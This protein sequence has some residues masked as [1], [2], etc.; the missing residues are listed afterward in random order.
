MQ[1]TNYT[2]FEDFGVL[3]NSENSENSE[4]MRNIDIKTVDPSTLVDI[5][6]VTVNT[7]LPKNDRIKDFI[8]QI[9]NPYCYKCGKTIVKA[10]YPETDATFEEIFKNILINN[11]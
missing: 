1:N 2:N 3:E 5:R 8:R 11:Y 10:V 7:E 6:D 4:A 9:K